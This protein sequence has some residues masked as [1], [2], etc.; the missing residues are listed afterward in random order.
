MPIHLIATQNIGKQSPDIA[1]GVD[2]DGW[3]DQGIFW[4][5][6]VNSPET[7]YMPRDW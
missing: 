5:M 1:Q 2:A 6:A 7:H 4:G 3:C